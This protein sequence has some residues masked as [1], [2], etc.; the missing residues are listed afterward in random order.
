MYQ[1]RKEPEQDRRGLHT[2]TFR[3][4]PLRARPRGGPVLVSPFFGETGRGCLTAGTFTLGAVSSG[5]RLALLLCKFVAHPIT[6]LLHFVRDR[7]S[8][9]F[10]T[11]RGQQQTHAYSDANPSNSAP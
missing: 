7:T 5:P 10:A 6:E 4:L 11:G 1:S 9:L 8:G 3:S 2:P